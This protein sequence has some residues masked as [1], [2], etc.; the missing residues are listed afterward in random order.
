MLKLSD[1]PEILYPAVEEVASITGT[2]WVGHTKSRCEKA[3]ASD[4]AAKD[5]AYFL[6]M[7]ER[8]TFSGGRKRRG[9]TPLFPGY[10]FFAGNEQVRHEA[11]L[12]D[13]LCA[14]IA[15]PHQKQLIN[16]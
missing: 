3:F 10:V 2:W 14:V 8:V 12:T 11:L 15:P 1:N 7:V 16:E 6:P 4:L 5:I 9:M 13:R